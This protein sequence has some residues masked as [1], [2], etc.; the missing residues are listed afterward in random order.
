MKALFTRTQ[1]MGAAAFIL[2]ASVLLSRVMG[3]IRD[4][5]I[6][7]MFGAGAE[8]DVYFAA[9]VIPDFINYLLAGGYFSITLIPLLSRRFQES[10]EA[11]WRFFSAVFWWVTIASF[12]LCALAWVYAPALAAASFPRFS[13]AEQARLGFFLRI[14]VPAQV[15]FLPGACLTALLYWRRQFTVPALT[16]LVY[17]GCIILGGVLMGTLAPDKGMEGFCWGVLAGALLSSFLLPCLAARAGGLHLRA[18]LTD[19]GLKRFVILALPLMLGQSI[20]ALD[21]QFLRIFGGMAGEG[22]LSL[23]SY[24]RRLMQVPVGV[25]AQAA[26]VASYPF[27]AAL[28]AGGET[29]R[30]AE[31][32]NNALKNS[33]ALVIPVCVWMA[34][35]AQPL[36]RLIFQQGRFSAADAAVSATLLV[37]MLAGVVFWAVQQLMG[38]AFYAHE[39]TITPVLAGSAATV[40]TLPVYWLLTNTLDAAGV[41]LAGVLGVALYT[42]IL[43]LLWQRRHG[44]AALQGICRRTALVLAMAALPGLCG[45]FTARQVP[46]MLPT[47]G[48][49]WSAFLALSAGG[50]VFALLYLP[51]IARLAPPLLDPLRPFLRKA[52]RLAGR[53]E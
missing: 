17:N 4:K 19:S 29:Q 12:S 33:L 6:A 49:L 28:A 47:V 15:C 27:L 1:H 9:F 8:A 51:L 43:A 36:M 53:K 42:V 34:A 3:L 25:V 52:A 18:L 21:E 26:G 2:G 41:A 40:L 20:V 32:L 5:V 48:P 31:T 50:L 45:F 22:N 23:L 44:S 16:P 39:N 35:T 30:F 37:I 14:I 24:A 11:G 10:E 13:P 46:L 7:A 38:R